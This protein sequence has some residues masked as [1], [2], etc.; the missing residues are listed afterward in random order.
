MS[1]TLHFCEANTSSSAA[2]GSARAATGSASAATG[3]ASAATSAASATTGAASAATG[4]ASA[5]TRAASATTSAAGATARASSAA[6]GAASTAAGADYYSVTF[7]SPLERNVSART[8]IETL[9]SIFKTLQIGVTTTAE[10]AET[11]GARFSSWIPETP[12]GTP[13][14]ASTAATTTST[15]GTFAD[16]TREVALLL[17]RAANA[18]RS[19]C[20]RPTLSVTEITLGN[21]GIAIA[22]TISTRRRGAPHGAL[23]EPSLAI[24]PCCGVTCL[25]KGA[26]FTAGRLRSAV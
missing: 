17:P 9:L 2:T 23:A 26:V 11:E 24:E 15:D 12:S 4:A 13:A 25:A 5:A 7:S 6:T 22:A 20:A 21:T 1:S 19:C 10:E 16:A 14:T 8:S 3:S 18:R